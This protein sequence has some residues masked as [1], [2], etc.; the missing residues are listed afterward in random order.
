MPWVGGYPAFE[1]LRDEI[2]EAGSKGEEP[3]TTRLVQPM[4]SGGTEAIQNGESL[5][6]PL[7]CQ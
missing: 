3:W 5:V 2:E 1:P 7:G 6:C 4:G